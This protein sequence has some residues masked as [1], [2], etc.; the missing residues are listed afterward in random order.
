MVVARCMRFTSPIFCMADHRVQLGTPISLHLFEPRYRLLIHL[1]MEGYP[2]ELRD[3]R[4]MTATTQDL[5]SFVYAHISPYTAS[6]RACLVQ[7]QRCMIDENDGTANVLLLPVAFVK[8]ERV[9]ERP[10]TGHLYFAQCIRLSESDS[11][12]LAG[13]EVSRYVRG[14]RYGTRDCMPCRI[15]WL[16]YCCGWFGD[17]LCEVFA[18]KRRW[19]CLKWW[20]WEMLL[21]RMYQSCLSLWFYEFRFLFSIQKAGIY[22]WFPLSVLRVGSSVKSY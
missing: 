7:V 18:Y 3:G 17:S 19:H 6:S 11:N 4:H 12:R 5:P 1:V 10:N 8:L 9:W 2:M 13:E 20:I 22:A 21:R 14:S 15:L 16:Q